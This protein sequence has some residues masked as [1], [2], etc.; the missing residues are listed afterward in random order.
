MTR[1]A[2]PPAMIRWACHRA[3]MEA[4]EVARKIPQLTGWLQG[5]TH[6]TLKQLKD[7][8]RRTYTPYGY[9]FLPEPPDEP[10]PVADFRTA[11]AGSTPS[12]N[13][14]D[15]IY[16]MQRRQAWLSEYL[17]E[18]GAPAL[19]FV[20]SAQLDDDPAVIGR[21]MRQQLGLNAD[22]ASQIRSWQQ[23]ASALRES[24]E[25]LR[26]MA[27]INGVVGNNWHRTLDV[28]EF[29]GFAL[30]DSHAP[31]IFVNGAD[32]KSAQMFTLAHELAH[33][34]LNKEGV[35]GFS[36]LLPGGSPVEY[37]CSCAAAECLVPARDLARHWESA[38]HKGHP[39]KALAR[40]FKVSPIVAARRALDLELIGYSV[41]QETSLTETGRHRSQSGGDFFC[42]QN[43][44]VGR[45]FSTRVARAALEGRVGFREAYNLTGLYGN[46]FQKYAERIGVAVP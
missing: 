4:E 35:S 41:F 10:L 31:L 5:E 29:R 20:G 28:D 2:V 8:A 40:I 19:S 38:R 15:T 33:I 13:L 44:R 1:V 30:T 21:T 11:A 46:S 22:W 32:A 18:E 14:L 39:Y 26:V 37:W 17:L 36:S 27:V 34:W 9:L 42:H 43:S 12:A 7:L 25:K 24:I 6:P 16:A 45:L 23:A 3:G